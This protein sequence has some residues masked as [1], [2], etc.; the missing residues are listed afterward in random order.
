MN[1]P[2]RLA[3]SIDRLSKAVAVIAI[4]LTLICALISAGNAGMRYAFDMSSN[5][6]LEMQWYMFGGMVLLGAPH[7]LTINGHIRVDL[8]YSRLNDRQRAWLDLA[9]LIFFLQPFC[10]YMALVC[11]PWFLESWTI[12]E[13]SNNA[14]GLVRWPVKL[15]FPIGFG[16]L[17]LQ[18]FS[19]IIKRVAA[20]KGVIALNTHYERPLQ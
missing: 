12:G 9:G 6:W 14:G 15:L 17:V 3:Y 7:L 10:I 19:E 8:F 5:A 18:G 2:V 16:L 1:A 20:L 11:W 4:W 13:I